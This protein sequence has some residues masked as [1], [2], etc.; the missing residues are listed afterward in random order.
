MSLDA[1]PDRPV[2]SRG[3]TCPVGATGST[4][5]SRTGHGWQ[6]GGNGDDT[7]GVWVRTADRADFLKVGEQFGLPA[8]VL[9]RAGMRGANGTH[10]RAHVELLD[11]GGIHLIAPTLTYHESTSDVLT[12][13]VTCLALNNVVLTTETGD[14]HILDHVGECLGEPQAFPDRPTGGVLS[15]LIATLVAGAGEVETALGDAVEKLE[16]AVFRPTATSPVEDIYAL[17]R[18]IAEARRALVPLLVEL[19]ELITEPDSAAPA[20]MWVRRLATAVERV[21]RRLE[22]HDQLLADM[23]SAHLALVSVRQNEQMRSISAWA[24]ILAIPTFIASIYGMNF[25]NMPEREWAWGYPTVLALM[26]VTGIVL[27]RLFRRSGWL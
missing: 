23:L 3:H 17:K 19:P 24:A 5:W 21:D 14:A 25:V 1:S 11:G 10:A 26:T 15:A 27:H 4:T 2:T 22:D 12:G 8:D 6:P 20:D 16:D 7:L 18:E 13:A 9:R